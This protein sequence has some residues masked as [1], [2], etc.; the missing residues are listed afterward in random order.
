[1]K[2]YII[3]YKKAPIG[4][5][6]ESCNSKYDFQNACP[7][8]GTGAELVGKLKTKGLTKVK[9]DFFL[10]LDTDY[11]IS[12]NL[13]NKLVEKKIKLGL[14]QN[15]L[16]YRNNDLPFYHLYTNIYFPMSNKK[17]GLIIEN[18]CRICKRNGHFNKVIIGDT[19]IKIPTEVI[20]IDLQYSISD[21][22]FLNHSDI[23]Y[24]WECMGLSNKEVLGNKVERYARPLLIVSER[25]K[26]AF[27]E[28]KLKNVVFEPILIKSGNVSKMGATRDI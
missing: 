16:D 19:E 3:G 7:V 5:S 6:G 23:F 15:V 18:Q 24:T 22:S 11:I 17:N 13:Y 10:T 28:F 9:N 2:Y 21:L 12:E 1:M 8:C 25:I 27:E 4:E 20:P 14:L 26:N